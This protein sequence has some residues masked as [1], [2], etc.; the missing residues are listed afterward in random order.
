MNKI[1]FLKKLSSFHLTSIVI[2][3]GII[4]IWIFSAPIGSPD[5][6]VVGIQEGDS[7]KEVTEKFSENGL[8]KSRG[9]LSFLFKITGGK[10]VAGDYFFNKNDS[11]FDI[12]GRLMRGDYGVDPVR[13]VIFEG[14]TVVDMVETFETYLEDFDGAE[15]VDLAIKDEGYLFPDTYFI[16][17][18]AD[19]T[20]V[21]AQ[22][23][24]NFETQIKNIK[25]E[26]DNSEHSLEE[27]IIMA[28]I[29]EKE[30][31]NKIDK[32]VI[33]GVLWRRIGEGIALQVDAVFPYIIGKNTF[34]LTL[35]DLDTDSPYNTYR[36]KGLPP[37]PISNPGLES[38]LAAINPTDSDYFFYLSD[39]NGKMHY[40]VNF[41]QHKVNKRKY[42]N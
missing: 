22:M 7:S 25:K 31:G 27:V 35:D 4:M 1:N 30:A 10:I 21:V 5:S 2:F 28:S 13:V 40:A 20:S 41:E 39:E 26:V 32:E 38:I 23:K 34:E 6:P 11:S 24:S 29:L 3:L 37:G 12:V 42:L 18:Y 14:M 17:P 16:S 19:P 8:I 36:N 15:F 9:V 33:S